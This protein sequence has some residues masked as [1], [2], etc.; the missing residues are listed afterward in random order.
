MPG[1]D[2]RPEAPGPSAAG[3]KAPSAAQLGHLVQ[4]L[5]RAETADEVARVIAEEGA[6][7]TGAELASIAV[8]GAGPSA[9]P[10]QLYHASGLVEDVAERYPAIPAD[11]PTADYLTCTACGRS[12]PVRDGIPVLLLDEAVGGPSAAGAGG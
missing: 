3:G 7:A 8:L 2:E 9:A 5:S 12:F 11:D 10:A 1:V 6:V 4:A